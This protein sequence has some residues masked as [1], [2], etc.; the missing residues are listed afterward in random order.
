M[1]LSSQAPKKGQDK[2]DPIRSSWRRCRSRRFCGAAQHVA[3]LLLRVGM[4]GAFARTPLTSC[5]AVRYGLDTK[6]LN[7]TDSV[8]LSETKH[9]LH[10]PPAPGS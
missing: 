3:V 9:S 4:P 10:P 8:R 2:I 6:Q 7:P 1:F 5:G